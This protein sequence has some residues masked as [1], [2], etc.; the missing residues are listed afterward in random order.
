MK[1]K[2][3]SKKGID[4]H[5]LEFDGKRA[6]FVYHEAIDKIRLAYIVKPTR[7][8]VLKFKKEKEKNERKT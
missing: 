2:P 6:W 7:E 3:T 1:I 5:L 4:Y 8:E